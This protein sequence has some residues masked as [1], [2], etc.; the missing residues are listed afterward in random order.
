[1]FNDCSPNVSCCSCY[2][3]IFHSAKV[4]RSVESLKRS[5]IKQFQ[6]VITIER[7]SVHANSAVTINL[8]TSGSAQEGVDYTA[9]P[10]QVTMAAGQ[11]QVSFSIDA[12]ADQYP[13]GIED[14]IISLAVQ[15]NYCLEDEI[16]FHIY[17]LPEL[18]SISPNPSSAMIHVNY[19]TENTSSAYLMILNQSATSSSNYILDLS[20]EEKDINLSNMAAGIYTV[21]LI[22]DGIATD[23]KTLIKQ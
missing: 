15:G 16:T 3:Y 17:E 20:I 21:V 6:G 12:L 8:S 23:A 22:C 9:I 11:T 14:V 2:K 10:S 1:M 4:Q 19:M 13:E 5:H 18:I 7:L